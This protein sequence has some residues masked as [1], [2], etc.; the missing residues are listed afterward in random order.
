MELPGTADPINF[1]VIAAG[2]AFAALVSSPLSRFWTAP[3]AGVPSR[4][5]R[6]S[7]IPAVGIM[8]LAFQFATGM[9][10]GA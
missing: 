4:S 10:V 3:A 1:G 5:E 2:Y 9:P 6:A 7:W 8:I